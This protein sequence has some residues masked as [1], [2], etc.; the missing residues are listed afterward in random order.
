[1]DST[2]PTE[3][4]TDLAR[5]MADNLNSIAAHPGDWTDVV[6]TAQ[7]IATDVRYLQW[8]AAQSARE[9]GASWQEIADLFGISRQAAHERWADSN[10]VTPAVTP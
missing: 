7:A 9:R 3:A 8:R 1:M 10:F 5:D 4:F 2:T 6:L